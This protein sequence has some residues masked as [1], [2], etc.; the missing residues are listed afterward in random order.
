MMKYSIEY[1]ATN[2]ELR[3]S[4]IDVLKVRREEKYLVGVRELYHMGVETFRSHC[5]IIDTTRE[6]DGGCEFSEYTLLLEQE[7]SLLR[8]EFLYHEHEVKERP[9]GNKTT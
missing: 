2:L 4:A 6:W 7:T 5:R 8:W 9:G 1:A 3:S